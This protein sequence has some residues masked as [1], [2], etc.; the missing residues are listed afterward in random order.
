MALLLWPAP[1]INLRTTNDQFDAL[2]TVLVIGGAAAGAMTLLLA[3]RRQVHSEHVAQD[4]VLD[5]AERRITEL[6]VKA[7][8]QL[9]SEKAPVRLGGMYALERLANRNPDHRQTVVDVIC[10]YLRMPFN[11]EVES[12]FSLPEAIGIPEWRDSRANLTATSREEREVRVAAQ[13]ILCRHLQGASPL[14]IYSGA[15]NWGLLTL[16]LKGATLTDF[17]AQCMVIG[18]AGFDYARFQGLTMFNESR[19]AAYVSFAGCTFEAGLLCESTEFSRGVSFMGTTFNDLAYFRGSKFDGSHS[20]R[21][22][23]AVFNGAAYFH[24]SIF[25]S[26]AD[27]HGADFRKSTT[28]AAAKLRGSGE[29][30]HFRLADD[31]YENGTASGSAE[32]VKAQ[33]NGDVSFEGVSLVGQVGFE[34]ARFHSGVTFKG[35]DDDSLVLLGGAYARLDVPEQCGRCWPCDWGQSSQVASMDG[36]PENGEWGQ[37]IDSKSIEGQ[38]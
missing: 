24:Q 14:P 18:E 37:L 12:E 7:V 10:S 4:A 38:E 9:G 2:R 25:S 28:F 5:A 21:F 13:E 29:F 6:Y 31:P 34:G 33:F 30:Q 23:G 16:N 1:M 26:S 17:N 20:S 8:E 32:F 11:V 27:F 22:R 3:A 35:I 19:F 36:F 15:E